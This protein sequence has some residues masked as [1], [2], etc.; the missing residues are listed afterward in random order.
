VLFETEQIGDPVSNATMFVVSPTAAIAFQLFAPGSGSSSLVSAAAS[1]P[2]VLVTLP[3]TAPLAA[4]TTAFVSAALSHSVC[5]WL[6][7]ARWRTQGCS[8]IS[9]SLAPL[10]VVC[11]CRQNTVRRCPC[12]V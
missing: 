10:S 5:A 8:R 6:D 3:V 1:L 4:S 9:T 7:S 12:S 11:A 2:A